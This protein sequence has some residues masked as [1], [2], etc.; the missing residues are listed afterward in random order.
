MTTI[1]GVPVGAAVSS[2]PVTI[3]LDAVLLVVG[4]DDLHGRVVSGTAS[5]QW[6]L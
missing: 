1:Q 2:F 5:T 4:T 3:E 6:K